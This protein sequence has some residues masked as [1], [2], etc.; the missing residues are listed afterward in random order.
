[1]LLGS[2][3][4]LP[5][6]APML[7]VGLLAI[8]F[9]AR[10]SVVGPMVV[11]TRFPFGPMGAL[12]I[13]QIVLSRLPSLDIRVPSYRA[14]EAAWRSRHGRSDAAT[15][16]G[17]RVHVGRHELAHVRQSLALGPLFPLA[18][19][20]CGGVS[21]RNRFERAAD[22]YARSGRGWWPWP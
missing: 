10:V 21:A 14:R 15:D 11:V 7:A 16:A 6:S 20:L 9:G 4:A 18:Y 19:L 17:E 22:R 12:A 3:W 13:G 8:P 2:L 1:M 5:L